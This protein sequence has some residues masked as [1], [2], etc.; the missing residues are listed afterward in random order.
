MEIYIWQKNRK[1]WMKTMND[2]Y[3]YRHKSTSEQWSPS[4]HGKVEMEGVVAGLAFIFSIKIKKGNFSFDLNI[5][6]LSHVPLWWV[7]NDRACFYFP[8][9][10]EWSSECPVNM[11]IIRAQTATLQSAGSWA[12][13][14]KVRIIPELLCK[15]IR[16]RSHLNTLN[17]GFTLYITPTQ[18]FNF[19]WSIVHIQY[20][21]SFKSIM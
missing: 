13:L 4:E 14:L 12:S 16:S 15:E 2:V 19:N 5:H 8:W 6:V 10:E 21:I 18:S 17:R 9:H 1:S 20:Y 3:R 11:D 7:Y